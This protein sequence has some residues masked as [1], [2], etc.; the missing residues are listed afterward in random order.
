MEEGEEEGRG[1]REEEE[2]CEGFGEA[3]LGDRA[4]GVED[5]CHAVVRAVFGAEARIGGTNRRKGLSRS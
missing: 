5:A 2:G 3:L 4:V 1:E